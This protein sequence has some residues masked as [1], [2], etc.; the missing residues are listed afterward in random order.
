MK[1]IIQRI[2]T[3]LFALSCLFVPVASAQTFL[4]NGL[5]SFYPL[6]GNAS[7]AFGGNHGTIQN[8]SPAPDVFGRQ[9]RAFSFQGNVSSFIELPAKTGSASAD[10]T[11]SVWFN[12][13]SYPGTARENEGAFLI[14]KGQNNFEISLGT[15]PGGSAGI[16][17][18]PRWGPGLHWDTPSQVYEIN[19]WYHLVAIYQPSANRVKLFLNAKEVPLSG[20]SSVPSLPDNDRYLP[21]R[22]GLRIS[23]APSVDGTLPFN[24]LLDNLRIYDRALTDNEISKLYSFESTPAFSLEIEVASIRLRWLS[25]AGTVYEIQYSTALQGWTPLTTVGGTGD[26][27]EYIDPT[28]GEKR[29]YR[30]IKK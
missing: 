22:L 19:K 5:V 9:S 10:Y 16:R 21:V 12:S 7:D 2:G 29:F 8:A 4:T 13:R 24:G 3:M 18:L 15:P 17:F 23:P 14:S 6:D 30:I 20:P 27:L 26:T 28:Q 11:I 25:E 1:K